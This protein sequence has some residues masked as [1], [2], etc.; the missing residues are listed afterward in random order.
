MPITE[1]TVI[2]SC[3][4]CKTEIETINVKKDNMK[5]MTSELSW[6]PCCQKETHE[7]RDIAGRDSYIESEQ[8]SYPPVRAVE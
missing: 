2:R 6:C 1:V 3:S 8:S 7:T 5:L 4:E